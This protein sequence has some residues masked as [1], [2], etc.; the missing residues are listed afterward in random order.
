[1][2]KLFLWE[3]F[4]EGKCQKNFNFFILYEYKTKK[5][6]KCSDQKFNRKKLQSFSEYVKFYIVCYKYNYVN[7]ST[8]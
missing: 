5:E 1:M 3:V 7:G 4:I 8:F 6:I 2:E